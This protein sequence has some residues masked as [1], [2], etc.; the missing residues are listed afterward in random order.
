MRKFL[1]IILLSFFAGFLLMGFLSP[2]QSKAQTIVDLEL[3]LLVD[4]S[5]SIDDVEYDLQKMAYVSAF[6]N[7][8]I[9]DA[10]AALDFGIAVAYAEWSG[11]AQQALVVDWMLLDAADAVADSNA[12]AAAINAES[13][14]FDEPQFRT[15]TG[16]AINWGA[17][18][19]DPAVDD[20]FDGPNVIDISGDGRENDGADT[21]D[22]RD[23]AFASGIQINGLPILSD[24]SNLDT[25][26]AANV[27]T[28]D[29][30]LVIASSFLD[31]E[32]AILA[33]LAQ[34]I[35]GVPEPATLLLLG[36]G[37]I[38]LAGYGRKKFFKK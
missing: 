1:K 9:H 5:G 12:F 31:F 6:Q 13:R 18:L 32:N 21:S 22:A 3:L 37:L 30:F 2:Q 26:Y 24:D 17:L 16:S 23:A 38:G 35:T 19:F 4:V 27:I 7:S 20:E 33:K 36:S 29:G 28:P 15:A 14:A 11:A 34:E 8:S 10:I 25:W